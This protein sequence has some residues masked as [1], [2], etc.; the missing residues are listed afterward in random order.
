M[1]KEG[2]KLKWSKF[3]LDLN[4]VSASLFEEGITLALFLMF[5]ILMKKVKAT[6]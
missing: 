3:S 4:T 5:F 2:R 6:D 1:G